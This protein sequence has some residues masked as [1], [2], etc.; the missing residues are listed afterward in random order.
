MKRLEWRLQTSAGCDLFVRERGT[1]PEVI[2]LH[3]GFGSDHSYL[4]DLVEKIS[5]QFHIILYDQHG[6]LRSPCDSE[7]EH[8]TIDQLVNELEELIDQLPVKEV[9]LVGHSM[10][11]YLAARFATGHPKMVSGL[12]LIGSMPLKLT[13][14]TYR[15]RIKKNVKERESREDLRKFLREKKLDP[16][17]DDDDPDRDAGMVHQIKT[18]AVSLADLDHWDRLTGV[19]AYDEDLD[20][21]IRESMKMTYNFIPDL[22]NLNIPIQVLHGTDDYIPLDLHREWVNEVSTANL[23]PMPNTG[24]TPWIDRPDLVTSE[25]TNALSEHIIN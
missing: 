20:D 16:D 15:E 4:L 19:Y 13:E 23:R 24:H 8:L 10:G 5:D 7:E 12:I 22:K 3:G 6:S 2:T 11:G 1:G 9:P 25:L 21:R 14:Q 17:P 18:A